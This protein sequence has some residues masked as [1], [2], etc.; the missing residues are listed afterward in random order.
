MKTAA[1]ATFAL[2]LAMGIAGC[3]A[4]KPTA[5][6]THSINWMKHHVTIGGRNEK[7]PFPA[8]AE[9]I[10][11]GKQAFVQYCMVCH[12]LDGQNTGVPFAATMSP[13]VPSLASAAVQSYADG[14]LKWVIQHGIRPSGM[15]PAEGVFADDDMWKMVLYIRHLPKEGSLGEPPVYNGGSQAK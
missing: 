2:F 9:N 8:T 10:E 4:A 3:S 12:G 7:N 6:E 11:E 15:P 5:F 1:R 13:P 14:Q